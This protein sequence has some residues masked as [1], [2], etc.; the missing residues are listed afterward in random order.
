M[1]IA[2]NL[3]ERVRTEMM[4]EIKA[5]ASRQLVDRGAAALSLRAVARELGL[6][7]SA[8]Y[9][10]FKS[11]DE[12]LTALIVDAYD[13]LGQAAEDAEA[14]I[15]RM[16]LFARWSAISHAVRSWALAHPHE[17][18]LIYGSP[19]PGYHA[20]E[21]TIG[22]A[23]RVTLLL[24]RLLQDAVADNKLHPPELA[25][26]DARAS[27]AVVLL[28]QSALVGVPEPII[29]RGLMAWLEIFG[30]VSFELFGQLHN[31]VT[32]YEAF[33]DHVV[34]SVGSMI[35]L[36]QPMPAGVHRTRR[37]VRTAH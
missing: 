32:D 34:L 22:P 23:S 25:P 26:P 30:T 33:F 3:R 10:Y 5:A 4:R 27:A 12:L 2:R 35:G 6:V 1:A 18:A 14:G 29:L 21:A 19:V 17:Y 24:A 7:S 16:D 9:R 20:P 15:D 28:A 36:P 37:V 31:V 11:R 8:L 13:S